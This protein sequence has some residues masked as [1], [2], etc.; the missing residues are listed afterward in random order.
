MLTVVA[1]LSS[2]EHAAPPET[3]RGTLALS[4]YA[5]GSPNITALRP[6]ELVVLTGA[7]ALPG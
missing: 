2:T 3:G 5:D 7:T 6:W 4:N 1:N